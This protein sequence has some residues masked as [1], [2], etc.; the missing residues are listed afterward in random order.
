MIFDSDK[1]DR[2]VLI[3]LD[4]DQRI[5]LAFWCNDE[6]GEWKRHVVGPDGKVLRREDG[7]A[8]VVAGKGRIKFIPSPKEQPK[9]LVSYEESVGNY[10]DIF[11]HIWRDRGFSPVEVER[12]LDA[13]KR[14]ERCL[15]GW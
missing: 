13:K 4:T 9:K 12:R 2:G 1:G 5:P 6:T 15:G 3:D 14:R 7:T 10:Q 8:V 11:R